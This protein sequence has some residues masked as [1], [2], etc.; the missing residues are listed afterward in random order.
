VSR[1]VEQLNMGLHRAFEKDE[2]VYLLGE[3]VLDPYGG[4]FK[5]SQGLSNKYPERV[6]TS[7]VSEAAIVGV[8]GG[9]A[10]RGLR[11]VVEIMFGDFTT[12]IADQLINSLSKFGWMYNE[13]VQVPVVI[14]TP[15]GGRRGY[16]PTH[17]QTLEKL[18]LGT[19]GLR[20]LA[21]NTLQDPA[22]MLEK[23][24][25]KTVG[26][27]L[28]IEN[29]MLYAKELLTTEELAGFEVE[30]GVSPDAVARS[31]LL[32]FLDAPAPKYTI[33]TYGFMAEMAREALQRLAFEEELFGEMYVAG[34]IWPLPEHGGLSD[35]L[36]NSVE[37]TGSLL[38][39]EEGGLSYGWGAEIISRAA[40]L[41]P[42]LHFGRVGAEDQVI[43]AS[44]DLEAEVLPDV[45]DIMAAIRKMV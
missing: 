19:P 27:T 33:A 17:S 20:I 5:V 10:L 21:A 31:Y 8:A 18:F 15:M 30:Q 23:A 22:E 2:S 41:K 34:Q 3:D 28:F 26:P 11:P 40:Q 42:Q 36:M 45:D 37:R 16:G 6:F 44:I 38:S 39:L 4:A 1:I 35:L 25:L 12:L 43:P 24:I 13:Q 29:K 32:S 9:M 7:P 14:R